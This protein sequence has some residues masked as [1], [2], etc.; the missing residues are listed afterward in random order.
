MC[1]LYIKVFHFQTFYINS[2]IS[3]V[4]DRWRKQTVSRLC[5]IV[6]GKKIGND[7][8]VI[9]FT[10]VRFD[11]D[12]ADDCVDDRYHVPFAILQPS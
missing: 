11:N 4:R 8:C 9:L 5:I 2:K 1:V 7:D 6:S 12:V 3:E 10:I